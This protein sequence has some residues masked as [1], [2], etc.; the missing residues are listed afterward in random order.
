MDLDA[1][2]TVNFTVLK[3]N[4]KEM[5]VSKRESCTWLWNDL[6]LESRPEERQ[7]LLECNREAK[8]TFEKREETIFIIQRSPLQTI[9]VGRLG[10]EIRDYHLPYKTVFPVPLFVPSRV[11]PLPSD[12]PPTTSRMVSNGLCSEKTEVIGLIGNLPQ[13]V[14]PTKMALR[15][16]SFISPPPSLHDTTR[17]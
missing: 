14:Q 3:C 11:Q 10:G 12:V 5:D 6:T 16:S 8:E 1:K 9:R 13:V 17:H 7:T 15:V 4:V 2:P